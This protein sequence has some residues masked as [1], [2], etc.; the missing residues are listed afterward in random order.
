MPEL[1]CG[2]STCTHYNSGYCCKEAILVEGREAKKPAYTNCESY[3]PE[4]EGCEN[5]IDCENEEPQQVIEVACKAENCVYNGNLECTASHI[6]IGGSKADS[7]D[8]TECSTFR[9]K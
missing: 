3:Y 1:N 8:E 6:E 7:T 4:S 5:S 2:V 9:C